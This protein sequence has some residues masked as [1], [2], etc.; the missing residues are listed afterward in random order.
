MPSLPRDPAVPARKKRGGS[1]ALWR[2]AAECFAQDQC[3]ADLEYRIGRYVLRYG[4]SPMLRGV[5][6]IMVLEGHLVREGWA[7]WR[8]DPPPEWFLQEGVV[9]PAWFLAYL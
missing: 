4:P 7:N 1:L 9:Y 5:G 8:E 2:E 6:A 3:A